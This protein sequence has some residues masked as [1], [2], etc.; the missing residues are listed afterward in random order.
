MRC[1]QFVWLITGLLIAVLHAAAVNAAFFSVSAGSEENLPISLTRTGISFQ[2][3][4]DQVVEVNADDVISSISHEHPEVISIS[5]NLIDS[6]ASALPAGFSEGQAMAQQLISP[7]PLL[8]ETLTSSNIPSEHVISPTVFPYLYSSVSSHIS[9]RDGIELKK[10]IREA[11]QRAMVHFLLLTA[12]TDMGFNS[13]NA[14]E[15][16]KAIKLWLLFIYWLNLLAKGTL[17]G[18]IQE[19]LVAGFTGGLGQNISHV[20]TQSVNT[21]FNHIFDIKKLVGPDGDF[22]VNIL[23]Q[24]IKNITLGSVQ[25]FFIDA[26]YGTLFV[27]H[28]EGGAYIVITPNGLTI[29]AID[30]S[31][32]MER[33][34]KIFE[35]GTANPESV[36]IPYR[37]SYCMYPP[38]RSSQSLPMNSQVPTRT[39]R[40]EYALAGVRIF[41]GTFAGG[42]FC[43]FVLSKAG[44]TGRLNSFAGLCGSMFFGIL[45]IAGT[46]LDTNGQL[47][48]FLSAL[49]FLLIGA[50]SRSLRYGG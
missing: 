37:I 16:D 26:S 49:R 14:T 3:Q 46:P 32:L 9:V 19:Q 30:F 47:A 1:R 20:T 5:Q 28:L 45:S 40:A 33:L 39:S 41:A 15:A 13:Q 21:I 6:Q 10:L 38:R 48:G 29:T 50:I 34:K 43:M 35:G 25:G 24:K 8:Q 2:L 12:N 17:P 7:S 27:H 22:I 18:E 44:V 23:S 31:A 4:G 36:K 42:A 11:I